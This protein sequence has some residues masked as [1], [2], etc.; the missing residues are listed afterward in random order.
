M[1]C[2]CCAGTGEDDGHCCTECGGSGTV[3]SVQQ[4]LRACRPLAGF[5]AGLLLASILVGLFFGV[6]A[7][8]ALDFLL[9][10]CGVAVVLGSPPLGG[11]ALKVLASLIGLGFFA[12][13]WCSE[14]RPARPGRDLLMKC[15]RFPFV[16]SVLRPLYLNADVLG[17]RETPFRELIGYLIMALGVSIWFGGGMT[18]IVYLFAVVPIVW[19]LFGDDHLAD[20]LMLLALRMILV[21]LTLGCFAFFWCANDGPARPGRGLLR[22]QADRPR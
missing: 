20:N 22:R 9:W 7:T 10:V 5:I 3:E 14:G 2:P 13:M 17:D 19:P 18:I 1:R 6:L 4:W 16:R 12:H 8:L 11:I 15:R 21:A